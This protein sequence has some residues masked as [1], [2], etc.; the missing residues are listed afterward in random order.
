MNCQKFFANFL[1]EAGDPSDPVERMLLESFALAHHFAGN[2]STQADRADRT[3]PTI[4]CFRPPKACCFLV[5]FDAEVDPNVAV[6]QRRSIPRMA[7][8]SR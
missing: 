7:L 3:S 5:L 8:K 6:S 1:N 2:W 4:R